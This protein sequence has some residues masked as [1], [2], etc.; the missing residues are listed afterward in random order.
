M[1][2]KIKVALEKL[3]L[4]HRLVFWYDDEGGMKD[5]YEKLVLDGVQKL[6]LNARY[7]YDNSLILIGIKEMS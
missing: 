7:V 6:L 5:I 1:I 4:Q 3:F 2:E